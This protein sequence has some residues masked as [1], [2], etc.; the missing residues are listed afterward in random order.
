MQK[1][2]QK[3]QQFAPRNHFLLFFGS[4][5]YF[6]R[7][8]VGCKINTVST[9]FEVKRKVLGYLL[10]NDSSMLGMFYKF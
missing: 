7:L 6:C 9:E 5:K 4:D 3:Q 10:L 1:K 2:L 8:P